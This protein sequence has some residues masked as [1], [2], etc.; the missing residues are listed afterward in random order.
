M[1][2]RVPDSTALVNKTLYKALFVGHTARHVHGIEFLETVKGIGCW[3]CVC[4]FLCVFVFV[5]VSLKE[6]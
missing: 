1:T 2:S 6:R 4:M 3:V 5:C